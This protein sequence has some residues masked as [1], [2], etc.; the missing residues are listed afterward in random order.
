MR[1]SYNWLNSIIELGKTPQELADILTALGLEVEGMEQIESV[2]G[3]LKGIVVGEVLECIP[4]PNADRLKLTKV[5]LGADSAVQIVCGAPNVSASQKVLVA[6]E[7]A[8]LYPRNGE[9]FSIKKSRIRGE[10]SNGMICS[11]SELGLSDHSEGIMVLS[12]DA[13]PGTAASQV[14]G[15]ESDTIF[16]IGLTPNRA[17]A[18]SHLGVAKD[19]AA[20]FAVHEKKQKVLQYLPTVHSLKSI[21]PKQ[22]MTVKILRE[23]LCP[24]YSGVCLSKVKVEASPQWLQQKLI[25]MDQKPINNI[26]DVTN[27]ILFHYGQPLHAFDLDKIKNQTIVVNTLSEGTKFVTLDHQEKKLLATDL[28]ICDEDEQPLCMA[29]VMGGISSLVT[30]STQNIFLESA[31]FAAN[32]IRKSSMH[33]LL[34]SNAAKL[35]E[36]GADPNISMTALEAAVNLL[37]EIAGVEISSEW[38]DIYPQRIEAKEIELSI[39]FVNLLSGMNFDEHTLKEVL[40]GLGMDIQ[41]QRNG[42]YIVR[43]P[44]N[45]P[46]VTRAADVVE[47]ICRVYGLDHIP[48]PEKIQISF[49]S[50]ISSL[51]QLRSELANY[52]VA[53]GLNEIVSLSLCHSTQCLQSGIWKEDELVYINNTSNTNLDVMLPSLCMGG[54]QAISFNVNRQQSDLSLFEI[55]KSYLS[56]HG[57]YTEQQHLSIFL[58]GGRNISNWMEPKIQNYQFFDIKSRMENLFSHLG[59]TDLTLSSAENNSIYEYSLSWFNQN[60]LLGTCGLLKTNLLRQF[61]LKKPVFYGELNL[62]NLQMSLRQRKTIFSE[63]SKFPSSRRDLAVVVDQQISYRQIEDCIYSFGGPQIQ[64]INLFDLYTNEEQLGKNKKSFAISFNIESKEK[65]LS[66]IELDQIVDHIIQKL[67]S[68]LQAVIRR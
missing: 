25:S 16:E 49:P 5:D 34:R 12:A 59:C 54:L 29:G 20:W 58:T 62:Q 68:E 57:E 8:I 51:Y 33:H 11:E 24:R 26:V 17:D 9:P 47:E 50:N 23:D 67:G 19:L 28:M 13:I 32:S 44:S 42:T 56:D 66:S 39:D 43:V 27:Y 46:D 61:D 30:E 21:E 18:T 60:R 41:D 6:T 37:Q 1:I 7:G 14:L 22:K 55:G 35:F 52:C 15:I 4:H 40:F 65:S 38:I 3:G 53:K 63:I 64:N 36:K 31:Y 10:E 2:T 45:K 48:V